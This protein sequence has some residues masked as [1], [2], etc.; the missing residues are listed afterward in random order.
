VSLDAHAAGAFAR[1]GEE[2][3]QRGALDA[4]LADFTQALKLAPGNVGALHGRG[5]V[6]AAR[7]EDAALSDFDRAAALAPDRAVVC[8]D[9]GSE[10]LRRGR[11]RTGVADLL[12][13]AR[14]QPALI[15][16]VLGEVERRTADWTA[17][18]EQAEQAAEVCK[19]VL[20]GIAPLL[21]REELRS[22]IA[23]GI[24]SARR[25]REPLMRAR[26]LRD[27]LAA[28]RSAVAEGSR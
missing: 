16:A 15:D 1:R 21:G 2:Y 11:L 3:C 7:G 24:E 5:R 26:R 14:K 13:A 23:R 20:Q 8:V 18:E 27:L 12:H 9:R 6:R 19:E 4:A 22:R 10:R 17:T 25:E 28:V